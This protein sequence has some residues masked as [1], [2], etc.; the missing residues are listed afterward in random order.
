MGA[1]ALGVSAVVNTITGTAT[2]RANKKLAESQLKAE[3]EAQTEAREAAKEADAVRKRKIDAQ[4]SQMSAV[5]GGGFQTSTG[6]G[7]QGSIST[8]NILG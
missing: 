7:L 5:L 4:R 3:K 8:S 6:A 2:N 1:G